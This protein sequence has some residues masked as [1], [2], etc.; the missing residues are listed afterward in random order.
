MVIMTDAFRKVKSGDPLVI[1][2]VAYNAMLD[3]AIAN[4]RSQNRPSP[5]RGDQGVHVLVRNE[6]GYPL[7]QFEVLGIDGPVFH[8]RNQPDAFQ[9]TPVLRGVVPNKDHKGKFVVLQEAAA[10]GSVVRACLSGLTVA[11]VYVEDNN[12]PKACDV[13]EGYTYDLTGGGSGGASILWIENG[14]GAKWALIRIGYGDTSI[15]F[16]ITLSKSGG[17][18]G[19]EKTATSWRYNVTH[20][21]TKETLAE[22]VNPTASPHQWRRPGIGKMTQATFGYAHFNSDDKL[23]IG[24]INE[25]FVL[26]SCV[27]EEEN[28]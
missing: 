14:T 18:E 13:E 27:E 2:A 3:A 22:D 19:D 1:P 11:R 23:V 9:Q 16:P 25:T 28:A 12:Q 20:A 6:S 15:L 10:P 26:G 24:W 7:E 21:L 5:I 17:E 8:P 4:M